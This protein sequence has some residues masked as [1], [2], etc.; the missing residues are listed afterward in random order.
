MI[1]SNFINYLSEE[2]DNFLENLGDQQFT[3]EALAMDYDDVHDKIADAI[4]K[5]DPQ[6]T[7][8]EIKKYVVEP[9]HIYIQVLR[10]TTYMQGIH[11]EPV[12]EGQQ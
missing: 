11:P 3:E 5:F 12:T 7:L 6:E 10:A 1:L 9:N 4:C 8:D 2:G